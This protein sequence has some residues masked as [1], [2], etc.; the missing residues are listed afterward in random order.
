MK[1]T[2][3]AQIHTHLVKIV[4]NMMGIIYNKIMMKFKNKYVKI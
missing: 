3:N 2:K 4:F 1:K